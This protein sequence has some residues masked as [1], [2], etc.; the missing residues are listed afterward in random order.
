MRKLIERCPGCG[1]PLAVSRMDCHQCH[2]SVEGSFRPS[3]FDRL[4]PESLAF[5][6]LFVRLK[7]NMKEM[8]R[9]LSLAYSTVRHRLDEV[10]RELGPAAPQTEEAIPPAP[11]EAGSDDGRRN[12]ILHRLD[13]GEITPEEAVQLLGG[14]QR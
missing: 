4:S 10:V 8:A 13:R 14:G 12:D 5:V 2:T 9:E 1:G 6:E 3:A 7:G 11:Q